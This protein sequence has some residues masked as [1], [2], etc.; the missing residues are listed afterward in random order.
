MAFY[1]LQPDPARRTVRLDALPAEAWTNVVGGDEPATMTDL[2]R[3]V[4]FL[5]RCVTL[6]QGAVARMPFEL[7]MRGRVIATFDGMTFDNPPPQEWIA[8]LPRWLAM[9]EAA[10]T[11]NGAAYFER[12]TSRGGGTIGFDWR[13]PHT[14]RPIWNAGELVGFKPIGRRNAATLEPADV[15]Y[16][17]PPDSTVESGPAKATPGRAALAAAGVLASVDTFLTTYFERGMIRATLLT[18]DGNDLNAPTPTEKEKIQSWWQRAVSGLKNSFTTEVVPA[19]IQPIT[20][21]ESIDTLGNA[22]LETTKREAI[23]TAIGVPISLVSAPVG[24]LGDHHSP[25]QI[26]FIET[27]VLP[28]I[29]W[30]YH[31]VNSQMLPAGLSIAALPERLRVM[32]EDE[33]QRAQAF[34]AYRAGGLS[35]QATAAVLGVSLPDNIPLVDPPPLSLEPAK[36]ADF[37]HVLDILDKRDE[38]ARLRRWLKARPTEPIDNFA[39]EILSRDE[40]AAVAVKTREPIRDAVLPPI[41]NVEIQPDDAEV[42][43]AIR[44]FNK[45]FPKL[46]GLLEAD[47]E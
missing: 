28:E 40:I 22:T 19:K 15:V 2:Y 27:T 34:A 23:A 21:G 33:A 46:A 30:L 41:D 47:V 45:Q 43:D 36:S 24:G 25:D 9:A 11:L 26:A 16:F 44:R 4:A 31:V 5:Y 8:N 29:V 10:A 37:A 39:S 12:R 7:K 20:I 35:L 14:L 13:L 17:W 1:Y 38:L 6:R 42:A 32:Q 3:S 18:Y